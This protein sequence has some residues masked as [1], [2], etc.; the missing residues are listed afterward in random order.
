MDVP[1]N[2]DGSLGIR[3]AP[4]KPSDYVD[5]M[6]E[7]DI[8][9]EIS[10]C[11]SVRSPTNAYNPTSLMAVVFNPNNDYKV[12]ADSPPKPDVIPV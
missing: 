8:I 6:A 12:K 9:I 5:L 3:E 2:P 11:P 4:S 1:C 7:I 10:N